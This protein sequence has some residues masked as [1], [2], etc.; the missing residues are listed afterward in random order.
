MATRDQFS[1]TVRPLRLTVLLDV[2][3]VDVIDARKEGVATQMII[4]PVEMIHPFT[5]T[6]ARII[7]RFQT[8]CHVIH[9]NLFL[10]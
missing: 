9:G 3:S 5:F 4:G 1:K 8:G 10:H 2:S 7:H 6:Q